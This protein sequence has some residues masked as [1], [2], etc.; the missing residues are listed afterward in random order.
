MT[1]AQDTHV[2]GR[3]ALSESESELDS[4]FPPLTLR[5]GIR[6]QPSRE[7]E[8]GINHKGMLETFVKKSSTNEK[9]TFAIVE[10]DC[11]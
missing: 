3:I 7:S 10:S 8:T 9:I 2:P 6:R 1:K 4:D 11:T 5:R